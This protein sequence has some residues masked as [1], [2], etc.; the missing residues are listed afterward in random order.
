ML[1]DL[2]LEAGADDL[3][4]ESDVFVVTTSPSA[5]GTVQ[6]AM[7]KANITPAESKL[8][9]LPTNTVE[10]DAKK[11]NQCLKLLEILEDHDDVQNVYANLTFDEASV[12]EEA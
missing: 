5:F 9:M 8:A 11:A 3:E 1:L 10:L 6:D 4:R 7:G 2:V 12:A